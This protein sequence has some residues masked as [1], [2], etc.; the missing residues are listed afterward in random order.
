MTYKEFLKHLRKTPR[1]WS[2]DVSGMLRLRVKIHNA[3]HCFCPLTAVYA[4]REGKIVRTGRAF[5]AA[6]D[7]GMRQEVV[8][9][10]VAAADACIGYKDYKRIR[11]D[12]L[13]ATGMTE[14]S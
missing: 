3:A 14:D 10:I 12:L 13:R 5:D 6:S 2:L 8:E 11:R 4:A 9:G 7:M 1:Q